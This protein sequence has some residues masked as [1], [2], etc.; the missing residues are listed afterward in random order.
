MCANPQSSWLNTIAVRA[1]NL[2]T[3]FEA[4]SLVKTKKSR[5]GWSISPRK[6]NR[7]ETTLSF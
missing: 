1:L 2:F 4:I 3:Y 6:K 5:R 7:I